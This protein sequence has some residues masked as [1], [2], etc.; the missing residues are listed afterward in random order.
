MADAL[1]ARLS[2]A[3]D[4]NGDRQFTL[5]WDGMCNTCS[6]LVDVLERWDS[7]GRIETVP[8]QDP[9]V[10]TRFPWI[11]AE[12][13]AE[14]M[15]LIGPGGKTWQ[16][17]AAVEQLLTVLPHGKALGWLFRLPFADRFADRLYRWFARNRYRFG[18]GDHCQVRG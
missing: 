10:A 11:P 12:A 17:A 14:A 16:G 18:C 4:V 7:Q 2:A 9:G 6:R 13:Y 8:F 1:A 15:Q 3:A 5:V